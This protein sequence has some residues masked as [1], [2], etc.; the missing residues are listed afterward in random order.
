MD[1]VVME[2]SE[3][4]GV[5]GDDVEV[6]CGRTGI[7]PSHAQAISDPWQCGSK[8]Q[9]LQWESAPTIAEQAASPLEQSIGETVVD[10][11][12]VKL[13]KNTSFIGKTKKMLETIYREARNFLYSCIVI[14]AQ[15]VSKFL[16][17]FIFLKHS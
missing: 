1:T 13:V 12:C 9:Y 7:E 11:I 3:A 10:A 5:E 4:S 15:K 2:E 8:D 16:C 17:T 14:Q 6:V